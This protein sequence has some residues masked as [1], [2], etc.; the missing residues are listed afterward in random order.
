[1]LP[2]CVVLDPASH[3]DKRST[4][5][6]YLWQKASRGFPLIVDKQSGRGRGQWEVYKYLFGTINLSFMEQ[7]LTPWVLPISGSP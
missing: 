6:E 7:G 4:S 5:A 2:Y 1:M 3:S